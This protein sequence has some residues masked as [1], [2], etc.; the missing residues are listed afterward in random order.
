[1]IGRLKSTPRSS[2]VDEIFYPGEIEARNTERQLRDGI[3]IPEATLAE[4]NV[5]ARRLGIPA[6]D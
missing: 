4:L 5:Q 2:G 1:M 3:D 6:L